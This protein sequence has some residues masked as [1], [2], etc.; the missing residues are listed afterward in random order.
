MSIFACL[1][2]S[3][4]VAL[5]ERAI[6]DAPAISCPELSK[7]L[8]GAVEKRR[9]EFLTGR[10]CAY[11]VLSKLGAPKSALPPGPD[12]LP[13]WPAGFTGSITHTDSYC[14]AAACRTSDHICSIGIDLEPS[15]P[16]PA[17]LWDTVCRP[18]EKARIEALPESERGLLARAIFSAKECAFKAQFPI[19]HA[20]LEFSEV[21]VD[22]DLPGERFT[23]TFASNSPQ[24]TTQGRIRIAD[25]F[26]ACAV[27]L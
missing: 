25:G 6:A 11:E 27:T 1:L 14:A 26:V 20:M 4:R 21:A 7:Y 15:D 22:L 3:Q 12:R 18:E 17:D 23:A 24:R 19:T 16:L 10:A 9:R 2:D 8:A 5:S 13:L